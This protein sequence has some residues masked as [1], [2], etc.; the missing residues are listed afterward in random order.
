MCERCAQ[1]EQLLH[2]AEAN[3]ANL[4]EELAGLQIQNRR[5]ARAEILATTKLRQAQEADPKSQ[6]VRA[7]LDHW[8]AFHPRSKVPITGK[9]AD[10]VR[11]AL[12]LGFDVSQLKA[13]LDG[14]RMYPF[15]DKGRSATGTKAQRFDDVEHALRDEATIERFIRYRDEPP[16]EPARKASPLRPQNGPQNASDTLDRILARLEGVKPAGV[17]Q[18]VARCPAHE[19]RNASLSIALGE[20]GVVAHCHAHCDVADIADAVGVP[21]AEW[22]D[23]EDTPVRAR[24]VPVP[25]AL[26]TPAQVAAWSDRLQEHEP[27]LARLLELRG[28]TPEALATLRVGWD[29]QRLTLPIYGPDGTLVN[30]GRYLPNG[31]PKMLG[32]RHRDRGLFPAPESLPDG[33]VWVCEGEPDAITLASLGLPGVGIPGA[34]GW[35]AVWAERFSGR[36]VVLVPDCDTPG[37]KLAHSVTA[38]LIPHASSVRVLDI[39]AE[40]ADGYDLSDAVKGGMTRA[41]LE[42]MAEQTGAVSGMRAA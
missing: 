15:V 18:W 24:P 20:K 2:E 19:D 1:L 17:N 23:G 26:P 21:L 11:K 10:V 6:Q 41:F 14:L 3:L 37:R 13:A 35:R 32:L 39:A 31:K 12:K 42:L 4:G 28:W 34:N 27:M 7:V 30:V 25:D 36:D 5:A 33:R 22:F 16:E 9:R 8:H 29:G 40:R 38:S